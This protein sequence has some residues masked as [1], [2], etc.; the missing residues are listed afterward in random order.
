MAFAGNEAGL[1]RIGSP[2][3]NSPTLWTYKSSDALTAID[4]V[5]YFNAAAGKL[6]VGDWIFV[7]GA[8]A[9]TGILVVNANSRDLTANPPVSG[10]VDVTNATAVGTID[11]D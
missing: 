8:S 7:S 11:S 3:S 5:G 10:V 9:T 1:Q 2:N 6:K 4:A